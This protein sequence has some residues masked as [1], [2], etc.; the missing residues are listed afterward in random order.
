MPTPFVL[1]C[2]VSSFALPAPQ[3]PPADAVAVQ[4]TNGL[5]FDLYRDLAAAEPAAN[6]FASPLS[7]AMALAMVAEGARDETLAELRRALHLADEVPL[8]DLHAAFARLADRYRQ[9]GGDT[10]AALAAR[11]A[12]LRT[13]LAEANAEAERLQAGRDWRAADAAAQ[14]SQ[15]IADELN[16]ELLRVDRYELTLANAVWVAD[17][18]PLEASFVAALDRSYGSGAA[19]SLDFARD[20]E[21]ARGAINAWVAGATHDRMR[22]LIPAGGVGP[23]TPLVLTNAVWFRGTWLVPFEARHTRDEDFVHRDGTRS[24]VPLMHDRDRGGIGY[25]AFRAD[26]T[27]FPTPREVPAGPGPTAEAPATYPDDQGFQLLE[28]P[29]KGRELTLV[30]LLPRTADGLG[31]LENLLTPARFAAWIGA[32]EARRVDVALPRF[33]LSQG[34]ELSAALRALGLRRAF[35]PPGQP[36][37]AQFGGISRASDPRQ[38]VAIGGVHHRAWLTVHEQGTEAAAATAVAMA[39]GSAVR[40]PQMVP[41]VPV[42]RADRPFVFGIRDAKS[43]A[44]LFLGRVTAPRA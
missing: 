40:P 8:A 15:T 21:A 27:L 35:V 1:A 5:A 33:E 9:G 14:R 22:D 20:A 37:A 39:P 19:R 30:V 38:Q 4:A 16:R 13:Q 2:A 44:L 23:D 10:D 6:L 28:L 31:R 7:I 18:F 42:F 24:K 29:Y 34:H 43:G 32:L 26:G 41:F 11:I 36:A 3:S 12:G 25:A 17:A